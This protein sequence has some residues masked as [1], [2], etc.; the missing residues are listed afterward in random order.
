M[1][2]TWDHSDFI[3]RDDHQVTVDRHTAA[4]GHHWKKLVDGGRQPGDW[5]AFVS[6]YLA[7]VQASASQVHYAAADE[8]IKKWRDQ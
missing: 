7:G 1:T 6:G 2:P 5:E 8:A 4:L 3:R